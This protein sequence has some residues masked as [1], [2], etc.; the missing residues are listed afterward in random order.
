[1][2]ENYINVVT[3]YITLKM[4]FKFES[5]LKTQNRPLYYTFAVDLNLETPNQLILFDICLAYSLC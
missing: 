2:K 3:L 1:M 4:L 5:L